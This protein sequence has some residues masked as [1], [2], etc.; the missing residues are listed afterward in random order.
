[1]SLTTNMSGDE[2][3]AFASS[4]TRKI[5]HRLRCKAILICSGLF[6]DPFLDVVFALLGA[7]ALFGVFEL[8]GAACSAGDATADLLGLAKD[9]SVALAV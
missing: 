3:T 6:A 1:M 7:F 9:F 8:L 5:L 4:A 2:S